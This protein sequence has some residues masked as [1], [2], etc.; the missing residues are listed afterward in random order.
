MVANKIHITACRNK[1][2]RTRYKLR[3]TVS[4]PTEDRTLKENCK[5]IY[6]SEQLTQ[7]NIYIVP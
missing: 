1:K 4:L 3:S 2:V 7:K 6:K 5:R